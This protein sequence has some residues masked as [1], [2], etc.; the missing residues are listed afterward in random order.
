[1]NIL[2]EDGSWSHQEVCSLDEATTSNGA[3]LV[4]TDIQ[5]AYPCGSFEP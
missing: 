4:T 5:A 2:I 3:S 1:M